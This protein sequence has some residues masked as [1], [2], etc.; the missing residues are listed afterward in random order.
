MHGQEGGL[1]PRA[2]DEVIREQPHVIA[3]GNAGVHHEDV[4]VALSRRLPDL[5]GVDRARDGREV[6]V[7]VRPGFRRRVEHDELAV[8]LVVR[9]LILHLPDVRGI[10]AILEDSQPAG[11]LVGREMVD[12]AEILTICV[13]LEWRRLGLARKL[14]NHY[15]AQSAG[16][17]RV[18][19]E[20]AVDNVAAIGLYTGLQFQQIGRR[21]NYYGC[22]ATRT[23]ALIM[24]RKSIDIVP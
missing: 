17:R 12:E 7:L 11:F 15:L 4:A 23:D 22:G 6:H 24:A 2:L 5:A 20:V 3:V 1:H 10:I 19:L 14:L 16:A 13:G 9:P 21:P 8:G 18:V